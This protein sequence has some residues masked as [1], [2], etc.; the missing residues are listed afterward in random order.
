M[1][2]NMCNCIMAVLLDEEA[3][4]IFNDTLNIHCHWA[5]HRN[6]R[7][8]HRSSCPTMLGYYLFLTPHGGRYFGTAE[9]D[10]SF[11]AGPGE[12]ICL[13]PRIPFEIT[14]ERR[15]VLSA[16]ALNVTVLGGL[17]LLALFDIPLVMA[18]YGEEGVLPAFLDYAGQAVSMADWDVL[19]LLTLR[20]LA[21]RFL[22]ALLENC[23]PKTDYK[24][25]LDGVLRLLPALSQIWRNPSEP[26]SRSDLA[27]ILGLSESHVHLLF[28]NCLGE[29]PGR[30]MRNIRLSLAQ[31]KLAEPSVTVAKVA[32]ELGYCDQFHFSR[33][34]K[35]RFGLSPREYRKG[36]G[37]L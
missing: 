22:L 14:F 29:S 33:Q 11:T 12:I 36:K 16:L 7:E 27:G 17:D 5:S 3:F 37:Y 30:Y 35:S 31:R 10:A 1:G 25:R 21:H 9:G 18:D 23:S 6:P 19:S 2:K 26:L 13:P 15:G 20:S 28:K 24:E 32:E 4:Q 34:F 8:P